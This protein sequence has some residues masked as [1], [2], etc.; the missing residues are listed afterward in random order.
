MRT[1]TPPTSTTSS[2]PAPRRSASATGLRAT[3]PSARASPSSTHPSTSRAT[4]RCRCATCWFRQ[5]A[6]RARTTA[7]RRGA[8]AGTHRTT[9]DKAA[10][11]TPATT[12]RPWSRTDACRTGATKSAAV[13]RPTTIWTR[14]SST[15]RQTKAPSPMWSCARGTARSASCSTRLVAATAAIPAAAVS[16]LTGSSTRTYPAKYFS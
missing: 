9:K 2:S 3:T 10:V 12:A 15:P 8:S 16:P 7:R 5:T 4:S 13:P 1:A 11:S 14:W 6:A